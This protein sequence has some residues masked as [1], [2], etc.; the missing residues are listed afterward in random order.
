MSRAK[1]TI[2]GWI[3]YDPAVTAAASMT[4]SLSGSTRNLKPKFTSYLKSLFPFMNWIAQYN[5]TWAVVDAIAGLTVG[6]VVVPQ[7]MSYA[8]IATLPPAYGLYSSFVGVMIYVFFATSKDVTIG[9]VAVMSLEVSKVIASVRAQPGGEAFA[10]ETIATAL[11]FMCG[12]IVLGIGLLRLGWLVEFIPAPAVSGFMTGSAIAIAA[13]QTPALLG[14]ASRFDTRASTYK[15]IINTF[16]N[17]QYTSRD[18]A[19]GLS[20][21]LFLYVVRGICSRVESRAKNPRVRRAAFFITTL[22]TAFVIIVLTVFAWVHLRGTPVALYDISILKTVPSGFQQ[23]GVPKDIN[24]DL[25]GRLGG[26]IPV[27][28]II[29]LLEHITIAKSF[30]RVN[31]YKIDPNQELIAIGVTNLVGTFFNAYP[32]TGSF[33]RSAIKS[34]A[35]VRTPLA[36]WITGL[37]VVVALYALT[38]A[39]YW[40]PNAALSAVIIHAVVDLIAT[41]HQV[42]AFWKVSPVEALIWFVSVVV[43][44]FTNIENGIYTSVAASIALLLFRIARPRGQ[45]LGRVRLHEET[46]EGSEQ[47]PVTTRDVYIPVHPDGVTNPLVQVDAPPPGVIIY[48]FDEAFLFPNASY[49]SDIILAHAKLH[50]RRGQDWAYT[51]KGDR[52]WNDPGPSIFSKE[53][54][55]AEG[56]KSDAELEAEKPVLRAVVF[57]F[58]GVSNIDTTSV[59][60]LVDLRRVLERYADREIEFHFATIL[61][62][63]IKRALLAGGFGTG[64]SLFERPLEIAPVVPSGGE[65]IPAAQRD[66]YLRR[67][68]RSPPTSPPNGLVRPESFSDGSDSTT[69]LDLE[70]AGSNEGPLVS[71]LYTRFHVDLSSAVA[72]AVGTDSWSHGRLGKGSGKN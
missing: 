58:G 40:I 8:R 67:H 3:G 60:N 28:T 65:T 12:F 14:F 35:G 61:S 70:S 11:A 4:Q 44:V 53:R 5:P 56:E 31:N 6:M 37:V 10:P 32:A 13:G 26:L 25:I 51:K 59:Q 69:K 27:S 63:W 49:Y 52:P 66:A 7:S 20:G 9:P 55:P 17:L 45:F 23:M 62:P 39:F 19:Y 71:P 57:D 54:V 1:E 72:A 29:L 48:R 34:K 30:G 42:Y 50:T 68:P 22:R 36:G 46:E 64:K 21:L 24:A 41:P 15:V 33:S 43:T 47:G 2:K 16:K 38:G 18:A